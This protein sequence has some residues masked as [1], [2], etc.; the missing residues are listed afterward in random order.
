MP[1]PRSAS[2]G[3]GSLSVEAIRDWLVTHLAHRLQREAAEIDIRQPFARY[4]L[5]SRDALEI[6]AE[7]EQRIERRLSPSL[8]YD[9]PSIDS[10]SQHLAENGSVA[11]EPRQG[12]GSMAPRTMEPIAIVGLGCRLPGASSPESFWQFLVEGRDAIS[13]VPPNHWDAQAMSKLAGS[14]SEADS[15]QTVRWGGW[16]QD[17]D[18]FDPE[19]FGISPRE[20]A[21][22]D[23]QQRLLMEVAWESLEDAGQPIDRLRGSRTGVFVGISTNDYRSNFMFRT[24]E[25]DPY[26]TTGNAGSIAANRLSYFF[27][28]RGPSLAVDTAC[29][30]SLVAVHWASNSLRMGECDLALAG[31][32]N[33]ILSPDITFSFLKG[34]GLAPDG[35]CKAFDASADGMVR[36]EGAG[37]V[38]LKRL[39]KAQS[40]GDRIYAVIRGSAVNQDGRS[41]GITA[42]NQA[43]QEAVLRE[44]WANA[45]LSLEE[46]QY[47]ET[48]GAGTLLGDVIEANALRAVLSNGQ[49]PGRRCAM[50][51]VKTN[52]GHCESAAGITGL[53]KA[54]LA[55]HHG[56]IPPN[57]HFHNPSPHIRIRENAAVRSDRVAGMAEM[58]GGP[59]GRRKRLRF[60]RHKCTRRSHVVAVRRRRARRA[61][62]RRPRHARAGPLGGQ[63]TGPG[64]SG[65]QNRAACGEQRSFGAAIW[66]TSAM[67]PQSAGRIWI[68]GQRS[69]FARRK[70]SGS[71]LP[72]SAWAKAIR[73]SLWAARLQA[74]A[75]AW[76]LSSPGT[77]D[78]GGGCTVRY[79]MSFPRFATRLKNATGC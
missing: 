55:V 65:G 7:L 77:A 18:Q 75:H 4:G 48:H 61:A 15:V 21:C 35:R 36:S 31:G 42:P 8:I 24:M 6:A 64:G 76:C 58:R 41:N 2:N 20:A 57:L 66:R 25:L 11:A 30:S 46:A 39:S 43:A 70:N 67:R 49:P 79:G 74:A 63:S 14:A 1:L 28:F 71:V 73:R 13:A 26:W 12:G 47:I 29:S 59:H 3:N 9:Y 34:G 62:C 16:L 5:T 23:P 51:S 50:G 27:D 52:L 53:I 32:V 44:A 33:L 69:V 72:R 19:F 56:Q 22:I 10:L 17:V 38:V 40:D 68:S 60:W 78:N 37:L 45:G 54:A